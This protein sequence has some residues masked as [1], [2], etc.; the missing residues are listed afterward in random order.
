MQTY[1]RSES[2]L[3][4]SSKKCVSRSTLSRQHEH[5]GQMSEPAAA[6]EVLEVLLALP[7]AVEV[8]PPPAAAAAAA[9][10]AAYR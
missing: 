3:C 8:L 10:A 7:L 5:S 9:T 6:L 4:I 2:I 1:F